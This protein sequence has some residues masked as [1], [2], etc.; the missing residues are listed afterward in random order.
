MQQVNVWQKPLQY[1][2]VISLQLIKINEKIKNKKTH[3]SHKKK[4]RRE[5]KETI[6]FTTATKGI[7]YWGINLLKETKDL[8]AENYMTLMKEIKDNTNKWR[9]KPRSWTRKINIVKMTILP[10]AFYRFSAIPI[11]LP[12]I[13][14]K[15]LQQIIS[16]FVWKHK[17]KPP[18]VKAIL[19]K[20]IELEKSS[21]LTT[22]FRLHYKATVI[23]T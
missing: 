1:C 7:K 14:F 4:I 23:K 5:I 3:N 16:Q 21:F 20:R 2:K 18:I 6:S 8:Y 12:M 11:K 9:D 10:K 13:F 15:D 22:S 19:R 17:I